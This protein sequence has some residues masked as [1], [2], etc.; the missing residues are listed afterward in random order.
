M[1]MNGAIYDGVPVFFFERRAAEFDG[2]VL[3][4]SYPIA[5]ADS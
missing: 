5:T 3:R 1:G 4:Y 2:F